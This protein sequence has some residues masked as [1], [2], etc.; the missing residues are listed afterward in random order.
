M[1]MARKLSG[2]HQGLALLVGQGK[3]DGFLKSAGNA[4][5]LGG[6]LEDVRDAMMEYQV[7][8][9]LSRMLPHCLIFDSGFI[10]TRYLRQELSA[11]CESST[12]LPLACAQQVVGRNRRI[13]PYSRECT[14]SL[15]LDTALETGK[16]A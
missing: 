9:P 15:V 11:H 3:V 6:L 1:G 4:G 5:K 13:S 8:V 14:T 12:R 16:G 7:R 10:A 2:V